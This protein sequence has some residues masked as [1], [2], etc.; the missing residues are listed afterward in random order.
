MDS[1]LPSS[2]GVFLAILNSDGFAE[3]FSQAFART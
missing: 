3:Q 2:S 1:T